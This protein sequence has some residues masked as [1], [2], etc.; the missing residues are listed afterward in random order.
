MKRKTKKRKLPEFLKCKACGRTHPSISEYW[1]FEDKYVTTICKVCVEE[2]IQA[3][4]PEIQRQVEAGTRRQ[5]HWKDFQKD[6]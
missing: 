3:Q 2:R 5:K 4:V 1:F 6:D